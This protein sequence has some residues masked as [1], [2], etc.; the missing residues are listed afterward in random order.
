MRYLMLVLA[1]FI[2]SSCNRKVEGDSDSSYEIYSHSLLNIQELAKTNEG[3]DEI[4]INA[5]HDYYAMFFNTS[6]YS[7]NRES[8]DN[9]NQYLV[10]T[11][12]ELADC[13]RICKEN[14]GFSSI[15]GT[16]V[17]HKEVVVGPKKICTK[18][19]P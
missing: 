4:L 17:C 16:I 1:L 19:W 2:F 10:L 14:E 15:K 6:G 8:F 7:S 9:K 12:Q 5:N 13:G 11:N 3:I 18:H